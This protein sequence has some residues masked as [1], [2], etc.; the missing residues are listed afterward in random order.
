[1]PFRV[2]IG[3]RVVA[4]VVVAIVAAVATAVVAAHSGTATAV[5]TAS[6][7]HVVVLTGWF[8]FLCAF[9]VGCRNF[10]VEVLCFRVSLAI[11]F[12]KLGFIVGG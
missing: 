5:A 6:F 3:F 10:G 4:V 7:V 1:M 9:V 8:W 2:S 12:R 11:H